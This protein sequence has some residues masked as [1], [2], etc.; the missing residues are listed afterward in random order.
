[1]K[2]SIETHQVKRIFM[3][4]DHELREVIGFG[5]RSVDPLHH[6]ALGIDVH[7]L[8]NVHHE[9]GPGRFGIKPPVLAHALERPF[10]KKEPNVIREGVGLVERVVD[11]FYQLP[12][13]VDADA[14]RDI[15]IC[16]GHEDPPSFIDDHHT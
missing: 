10:T 6:V 16:N 4:K 12:L 13:L 9:D 3:H 8:W 14:L 2:A 7:A 5:D 15:E 1:M 11:P